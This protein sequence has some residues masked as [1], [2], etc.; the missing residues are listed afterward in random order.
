M[1]AIG[2]DKPMQLSK[3][4][5]KLQTEGGKADIEALLSGLKM[6]QE[7]DLRRELKNISCPVHWLLGDGDQLVPVDVAQDIKALMPDCNI[8]IIP[9]AGHAVF[10][11]QPDRFMQIIKQL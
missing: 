7:I 1:Q 10:V 6:L 2:S 9:S 11:S 5:N 8:H 4:L 3:Q